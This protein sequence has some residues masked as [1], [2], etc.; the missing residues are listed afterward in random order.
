MDHVNGNSYNAS[1]GCK[2]LGDDVDTGLLDILH[3][4]A[5]SLGHVW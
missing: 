1:P 2:C 5:R 4:A 3:Q